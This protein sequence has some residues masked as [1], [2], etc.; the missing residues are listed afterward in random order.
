MSV[1]VVQQGNLETNS[2]GV[3]GLGTLCQW[4]RMG[5]VHAYRRVAF[6]IEGKRAQ[7]VRSVEY[8]ET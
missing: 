6:E 7:N 1:A 2:G 4:R 3:G 8:W 5:A